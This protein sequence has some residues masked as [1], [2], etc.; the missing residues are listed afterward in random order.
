MKWKILSQTD[1]FSIYKLPQKI[2]FEIDDKKRAHYLFSYLTPQNGGTRKEIFPDAHLLFEPNS[3]RVTAVHLRSPF[4]TE[5]D[6]NA[7]MRCALRAHFERDGS[8]DSDERR[9]LELIDAEVVRA[10][11]FG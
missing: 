1:L 3:N 8:I 9:F 7:A 11:A 5:S 4:N 6:A 10:K 2:G